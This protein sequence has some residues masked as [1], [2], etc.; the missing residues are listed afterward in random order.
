MQLKEIKSNPNNP[1]FIKD[2]KFRQLVQSIS[3]FP[4]MME[5]RPIVID[6]NNI[7]LGGNMRLKA[8]QELKYKEIPDKWIKKASELTEEQKQEFIIK[9]NIGFGVWDWDLLANEWDSIKLEEWGLEVINWSAGHEANEMSEDGLNILEEFDPIGNT[10]DLCKLIIIFDSKMEL[11]EWV[12]QN[13]KIDLE[14][15]LYN[16]NISQV[17]YSLNYGVKK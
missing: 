12:R 8:L 7:V 11:D 2:E 9:D 3:D 14:I 15:K 17:N 13:I 10:T 6:E 4:K 1:R 16:N 5:L